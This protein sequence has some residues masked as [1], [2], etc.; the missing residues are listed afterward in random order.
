M[1]PYLVLSDEVARALQIASKRGVDVRIITPGIPDKKV[2]YGVT[3][4]YYNMLINSGIKIYEYTPGFIHSKTVL[5]DDKCAV[6]GTINL[7]FRS[8]Y[9]H[10]E[11]AVYMY[12][13]DCLKD[14]RADFVDTFVVCR[15]VTE[16]YGIRPN[17]FVRFYK[18]ILRLI[19]PLM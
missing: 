8:L 18:S 14:I 10:F 12:K 17:L 7:D 4:S 13:V 5:C 6:V 9:H 16:K 19:A 11:N 3:R 15:D 2:T 1:S